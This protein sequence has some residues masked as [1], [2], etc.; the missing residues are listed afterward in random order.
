MVTS[1]A[2]DG[3]SATTRG[4]PTFAP[5]ELRRPGKALGPRANRTIALVVDA[6]RR[7][8]LTRGYAGTTIDEITKVA[9]LSRASFYTYFPSKR[10]ALLALGAESTH[11]TA[12]IIDR[13]GQVP[14]PWT[15][16]DIVAWVDDYFTFLDRF[17]SFVF[18][19]TQA[20]HEDEDLRQ[21]GAKGHLHLC[22]QM[23]TALS[24]LA[25]VALANPVELGL[26]V[27]AMLERAWSYGQLYDGLVGP[28]GIVR[29][30]AGL[31]VAALRFPPTG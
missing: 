4:A 23:G 1:R 22:R 3:G 2:G 26:D 8:F 6:T 16:A 5:P 29:S 14:Q 12:G 21:A 27:L 31:L 24:G 30:A 17:G 11:E 15:D 7:V 20:A 18:A 10:D 9:D 28:G 19:W 25:G 13:L